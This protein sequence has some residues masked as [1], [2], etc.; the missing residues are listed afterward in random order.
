MRDII[1]CSIWFRTELLSYLDFKGQVVESDDSYGI[2]FNVDD[3][4]Y[5][6]VSDEEIYKL[7]HKLIESGLPFM[8][9]LD[10]DYYGNNDELVMVVR[11]NG[12]S[13][14]NYGKYSF[15]KLNKKETEILN[16]YKVMN[17]V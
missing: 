3:V 16:F 14:A 5:H 11:F 17:K 4:E 1:P 9:C 12:K 15:P 2:F 13:N 10:M 8:I 7:F 6:G